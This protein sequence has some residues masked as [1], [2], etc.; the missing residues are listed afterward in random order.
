MGK[1]LP[2]GEAER[3][4]KERARKLWSGEV[5]KKIEPGSP[6][7]WRA[8]A[9][10]FMDGDIEFVTDAHNFVPP[11]KSNNSNPYLAV[12]NL[13]EMPDDFVGLKKAYRNAIMTAFRDNGFKDTSPEYV[14][15]FATI[16]TA[17]D[18]LRMPRGWR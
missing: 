2:P 12:L 13:D 18:R 1:R 3:R 8:A 16:T 7:A 5:Y 14:T 15:A 6:E 10:A 11:S 9:A 4:A 17:Y